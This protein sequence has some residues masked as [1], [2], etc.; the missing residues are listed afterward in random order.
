M[1]AGQKKN[2]CSNGGVLGRHASL[3]AIEVA[4]AYDEDKNLV[5]LYILTDSDPIYD[6]VTPGFVYGAS[7][8]VSENYTSHLI[9]TAN[10]KNPTGGDMKGDSSDYVMFPLRFS[11]NKNDHVELSIENSSTF[12]IRVYL[13][14]SASSSLSVV[15]EGSISVNAGSTGLVE[16]DSIYDSTGPVLYAFAFLVSVV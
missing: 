13:S 6:P 16:F 5:P 4:R 3:M 7:A 11:Y 15:W 8:D 1:T 10:S 2:V 14:L 12:N 9:I